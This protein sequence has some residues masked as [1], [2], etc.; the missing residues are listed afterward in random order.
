MLPWDVWGAQ[1]RQGESL[2]DDQL[3]F[4]DQLAALTREPDTSFEELHK[5]FESDNRLRAPPII[6]NSL[7]NHSEPL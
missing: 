2:N 1:P 4:F 6:F 5:L 7:L 3:A